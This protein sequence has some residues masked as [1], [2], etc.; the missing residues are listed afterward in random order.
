MLNQLLA[1]KR[2]RETRIRHR[3]AE[4]A[5]QIQQIQ[6]QQQQGIQQRIDLR[7][8]WRQANQQ[9]SQVSEGKLYEVQ[10]PLSDFYERDQAITQQQKVLQQ[11]LDQVTA[12]RLEQQNKLQRNR[13]EQEKLTYVLEE[14]S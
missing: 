7:E 14:S 5:Q 11:E 12:Q 1:L 2:R 4:C 9:R 10:Q 8:A 6:Q 3:I 13:I